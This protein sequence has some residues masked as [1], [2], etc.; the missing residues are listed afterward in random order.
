MYY[1]IATQQNM[2]LD[3][4]HHYHSELSRCGAS[5]AD[6]LQQV[7][8][9]NF[10]AFDAAVTS[11]R[12]EVPQYWLQSE[13]L[14]LTDRN[15]Y[16]D[17]VTG[18]PASRSEAFVNSRDNFVY[19]GGVRSS[20]GQRFQRASNDQAIACLVSSCVTRFLGQLLLDFDLFNCLEL[21]THRPAPIGKCRW[22][23]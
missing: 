11:S 6:V 15:E 18:L 8:K 20:I 16:V 19:F 21:R 1:N 5:K 2:V 22:I 14:Q 10:I 13:R 7:A 3:S 9:G 4:G 23:I 17:P 12:M